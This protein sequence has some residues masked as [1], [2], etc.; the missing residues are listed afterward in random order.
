MQPKV[1]C[2]FVQL[3]S[4]IQ[5]CVTPRAAARQASLCVTTSWSLLKFTSFKSVMVS[6]YLILCFPLLLYLQSFPAS[7][8]FPMNWLFSSGGQSIG[9]S[10]FSPSNEYSGLIS[11]RID[12]LE[13]LAVQGT[14]KGLIQYRNSKALI[15]HPK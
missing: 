1:F 7:G 11:F 6:N 4:L 12:W 5:L 9:T 15:L 3:L 10:A 14:L 2:L 8:S 13:L